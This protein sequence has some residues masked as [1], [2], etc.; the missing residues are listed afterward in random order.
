M[1]KTVLQRA[2]AGIVCLLTLTG[3]ALGILRGGLLQ[4][5]PAESGRALFESKGCVRCHFTNSTATKI[6]PGL[7]GLFDRQRLPAS[8]RPVNEANLRRQLTDPYR[9]M[10]SFADR[11]SQ[12]EMDRIIDY[13][14]TL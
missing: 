7:Q 10:P 2:T 12:L 5:P 3:I 14:R 4:P 1:R 13:L 9:S 11:L 6:G 8:E